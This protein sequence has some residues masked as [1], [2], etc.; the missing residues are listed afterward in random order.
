MGVLPRLREAATSVSGL[1]FVS[2][3]GRRVGRIAVGKADGTELEVARA[4]LAAVMYDAARERAE[5]VFGDSIAALHQDV[6]AWTSPS[7]RA[8]RAGLTSSSGPTGCT[9]GCAA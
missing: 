9:R 8:P 3:S 5:F 6:P 2:A 1:A 4:N 7:P